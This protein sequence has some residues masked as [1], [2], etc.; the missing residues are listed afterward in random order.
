[1]ST[2]GWHCFYKYCRWWDSSRCHYCCCCFCCCC[3]WMNMNILKL[4]SNGK[5]FVVCQG[6]L[7]KK[8]LNRRR[9]W[10]LTG[11]RVDKEKLCNHHERLFPTLHYSCELRNG[12][13][14]SV[15]TLLRVTFVTENQRMGNERDHFNSVNY[16]VL[17]DTHTLP[18]TH[19]YC[20]SQHF[21]VY[22]W[23]T[24]F[25]VYLSKYWVILW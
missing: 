9:Y 10:V 4:G 6:Q 8:D 1:M 2:V 5:P 15:H 11:E 12:W 23:R 3:Y 17:L 20:R 19:A 25:F 24:S 22:V 13:T 16:I 18:N 21:Y 14:S 7:K